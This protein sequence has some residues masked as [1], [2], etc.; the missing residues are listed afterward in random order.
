MVS[1]GHA[2]ASAHP[3]LLPWAPPAQPWPTSPATSTCHVGW[4]VLGGRGQGP[5]RAAGPQPSSASSHP[6]PTFQ[7]AQAS[8]VCI[9][10]ASALGSRAGPTTVAGTSASPAPAP[11]WED[12]SVPILLVRKLRLGA[13]RAAETPTPRPREQKSPRNGGSGGG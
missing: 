5:P 3:A 12:G 4:L 8:E 6:S 10:A 1:R 13:L 2:L 11:S 7:P 9:V